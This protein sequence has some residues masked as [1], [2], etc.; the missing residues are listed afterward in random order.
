MAA[1]V[2]VAAMGVLASWETGGRA[3]AQSSAPAESALRARQVARDWALKIFKDIGQRENEDR[4]VTFQ[5]MGEGDLS[6]RRHRRRLYGW[7]LSAL[8]EQGTASR[9]TVMNPLDSRDAAQALEQADVENSFKVYLE[10]LKKH[11]LTKLNLSCQGTPD[12]N[13][14]KLSCTVLDVHTL[15][16]WGRAVASFDMDWLGA[17]L[18]MEPALDAVA[19]EIVAGLKGLARVGEVKIEDYGVGS[20]SALTRSMERSLRVRVIRRLAA[21]R[22]HGRGAVVGGG[23][24]G[25]SYRLEGGVEH[26]GDRLVLYVEVYRNGEVMNA[27]EEHIE[28]ASVPKKLLEGGGV[29]PSERVVEGAGGEVVTEK[30]ALHEAVKAGDIDGVRGMLAGGVDV[31]GRD[32]RSWTGLM[33]AASR[34]Y[35]L[36]VEELL[37]A[38]ADVGLRAVDGATALYMAAGSGH[39]EIVKMLLE[40]GAD[41]EVMGPRGRRAV[42]VARKEGYAKIAELLEGAKAERALRAEAARDDEAY[43]RARKSDTLAGYRRYEDE[44]PAGGHLLAV[45]KRLR[46]LDEA[47]YGKA[48]RLDTV[49]GWA[50]Y[51]RA[52]PEGLHAKEARE[53]EWELRERGLGLKRS[54]LVLVQHG[55]VSL[56]KDVGRVDGVFGVRTRRAIGEW[57]GEK[58]LA[59][60]GYLTGDQARAL[61]AMGEGAERE[62]KAREEAERRARLEREVEARRQAELER[63]RREREAAERERVRLAREAAE[64]ERRAQKAAE[65]RAR[66]LETRRQA[67]LAREAAERKA[68]E[69][70]EPGREFRDCGE[71]PWMVVVPAGEYMMGSPAGEEGRDDDEGPRHRVKIREA[72][73]VGKYEV[74]FEEWDACV[75]GGGCGGYRPDDEGWGRGRRPVVN[76]NWEDAKAYLEWL[77]EKTGKMYRLLSEAE[78]EYATRA[79]TGTRYSWGDEVGNNQANCEGCGS[80]WDNE[81]TAPVGSFEANGFGLHDVH[82]N[83]WE[84]VEDCWHDNYEGAPT[85]GSA[86]TNEEGCGRVRRGGSWTVKPRDLRSAARVFFP[87]TDSLSLAMLSAGDAYVSYSSGFRVARTLSR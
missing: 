65:R 72:L 83:V 57:Q 30:H 86:W 46:E 77:R 60:T 37:G 4:R 7:L 80:R 75:D 55:L 27:V 41:T 48:R 47:A 6:S 8:H 62:R 23:D 67:E 79:K 49:E 19:G 34:G 50:E 18:T 81:K 53:K 64:R 63:E 42:E 29:K 45:R 56:G 24:E 71:C 1:A 87:R 40:A 85:D 10:T 11:A 32:G 44:H 22:A 58:G 12:G 52:F 74:T 59:V 69:E 73:A 61:K 21:K 76:V 78:W 2:L 68:R 51:R 70:R 13:W 31:N 9:Y 16:A 17:P 35:T 20:R 33:H 84:W 36:V 5:P 38:E 28:L 25:A 82:G 39:L 26:H 66:E 14:I 15:E 3:L 43:A 54:E